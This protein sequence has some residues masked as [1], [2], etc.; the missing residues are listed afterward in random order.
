[1][2][3]K[4]KSLTNIVMFSFII[5]ISLFQLTILHNSNLDADI[6]WHYKLGEEIIKN[7]SITLANNFTFLSNTE[8]V[9]QEWLYEAIL[10][11]IVSVSGLVGFFALCVINSIVM[12][13]ITSRNKNN[14]ILFSIVSTILI[15]TTPRNVGN[16]PSEFSMYFLLII[17][18]L[19]NKNIGNVKKV[20]YSVLGIFIAN[21]HGGTLIVA[22]AI[23]FIMIAN[24]IFI[25]LHSNEKISIKYYMNKTL[26]LCIFTVST[27]VNP[28]GIRLLSTIIKIPS[29]E[30][31]KYIAEWQPAKISY[32]LGI[33]LILIAI[34]FGY[35]IGKYGI[36]RG[37]LQI[38]LINTALL[39]LSMHSI[40]A[41][42]LFD[43]IWMMY[44]YKYL[45]VML[46][47]VLSDK[48]N[49]IKRVITFIK[50]TIPAGI[51]V[52]ALISIWT[53]NVSTY[54]FKEYAN[55]FKNSEI[56]AELKNNYSDDTKILASYV[57]GN[58]ILFNDMKC[59]IDTRQWPY[60]KE[61]GN[62]NAVDEMVYVI[63][64]LHDREYIMEFIDK[65]KF[66]YIWTDSSLDLNS[67][68]E[69]NKEFE[70]IIS[71]ENNDEKLWKRIDCSK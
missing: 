30:T 57:N 50:L 64:N 62:C 39:I 67:Y 63:N 36:N 14:L 22:I 9:H 46:H 61:L 45:E 53:L 27:I 18:Y 4:N 13:T 71:F 8:W 42:I 44:G 19:Y 31:T 17:I 65:Y 70:I 55:S 58:Y 66:D 35:Y 37:D 10:Y 69:D 15:Y 23:W 2:E 49:C 29:L 47:D 32:L 52:L 51:V 21:F 12:W 5:A 59:F 26:E 33:L 41:F 60:A 20:I 34:S 3:K 11:G 28:S 24:D 43:I 7:G 16:R 56:L 54:N 1:M 6:L 38:I 48:F 25:D 68:L 40:K